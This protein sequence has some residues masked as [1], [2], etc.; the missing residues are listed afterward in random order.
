MTGNA[1]R[2]LTSNHRSV[3]VVVGVMVTSLGPH[4]SRTRRRLLPA[5]CHQATTHTP[6]HT[7][8]PLVYSCAKYEPSRPPARLR[9][10]RPTPA[11]RTDRRLTGRVSSRATPADSRWSPAG[12]SG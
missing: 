4:P 6:P 1:P 5:P 8:A 7:P 3:L 11:A 2:R 12:V 9:R 10:P